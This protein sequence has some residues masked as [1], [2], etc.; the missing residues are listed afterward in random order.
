MTML[1]NGRQ[2]PLAHLTPVEMK[3]VPLK[4]LFQE[5]LGSV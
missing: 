4:L 2:D 5:M 1:S 3:L